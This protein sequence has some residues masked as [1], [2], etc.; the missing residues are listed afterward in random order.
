MCAK[1]DEVKKELLL[2]EWGDG[3]AAKDSSGG[4][5][6][7]YAPPGSTS[8]VNSALSSGGEGGDTEAIPSNLC[9]L[10]LYIQP[11]HC[12]PPE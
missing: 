3:V 5:G 1:N 7:G 4:G 2:V 10:P 11:E 12:L 8:G 6:N 9:L